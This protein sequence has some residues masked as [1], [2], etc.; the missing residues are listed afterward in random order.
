MR[1]TE[2]TSPTVH[3]SGN[4]AGCLT[5]GDEDDPQHPQQPDRPQNHQPG[6]RNPGGGTDNPSGIRSY[7]LFPKLGLPM[8]VLNEAAAGRVSANR[9]LGGEKEFQ[10]SSLCWRFA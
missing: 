4:S 9:G 8:G 1:G 6:G 3:D 5:F 10:E 7:V 2:E